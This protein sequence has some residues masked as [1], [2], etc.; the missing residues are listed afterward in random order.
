MEGIYI[1]LALVIITVVTFFAASLVLKR[2][3]IK[4]IK[5]KLSLYGKLTESKSSSFDY[6]WHVNDQSYLIK[7]FY[8]PSAK[9]VS[10]NSKMHWQ[11]ATGGGKKL[12]ETN[13][14]A[15]LEGNKLIIVYPNPGKM[16]KHINEN[17]VVFVKPTMD[18]F[19][20]KALLV[21]QIDDFIQ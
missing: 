11:V 1:F 3:L 21:E 10:F 18:I 16:V 5:E 7:L 13:G 17:E 15:D 6:T 12:F 4:E 2:K 8:T 9:E 20:M 19:G 14:F